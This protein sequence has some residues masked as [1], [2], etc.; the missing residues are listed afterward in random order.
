MNICDF[1]NKGETMHLK[2]KPWII[3]IIM[4]ATCGPLLASTSQKWTLFPDFDKPYLLGLSLSKSP[5]SLEL[6]P[7]KWTPE[8]GVRWGRIYGQRP[9]QVL[10]ETRI[11]DAC[12]SGLHLELGLPWGFRNANDDLSNFRRG[13]KAH[14]ENRSPSEDWDF[15][16]NWEELKKGIFDPEVKLLYFPRCGE[17]KQV[18][19]DPKTKT[20]NQLSPRLGIGAGIGWARFSTEGQ[21]NATYIPWMESTQPTWFF[22]HNFKGHLTNFFVDMNFCVQP[23]LFKDRSHRPSVY[24]Y[25]GL[26]VNIAELEHNKNMTYRSLWDMNGFQDREV[27]S[28]ALRNDT[29]TYNEEGV[30]NEIIKANALGMRFGIGGMIPVSSVV[31]LGI[32]FYARLVSFNNWTGERSESLEWE[33]VRYGPGSWT[34]DFEGQL[35]TYNGTSLDGNKFVGLE[36]SRQKPSNG[37]TDVRLAEIKASRFGIRFNLRFNSGPFFKSLFQKS[38]ADSN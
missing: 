8:R 37:F 4:V 16:F 1:L 28:A 27:K 2:K 18:Q 21:Y 12:G 23:T 30:V 17:N 9:K 31:S 33:S 3:F 15:N 32:E 26:S 10:L 13:E 29:Q 25:I 19:S 35:W 11:I 22:Y 5:D 34:D 36:V 14:L 20:R 7:L 24:T 38:Q 6:V